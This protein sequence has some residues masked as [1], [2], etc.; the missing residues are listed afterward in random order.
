MFLM[1]ILNKFETENEDT[2]ELKRIFSSCKSNNIS[3]IN[4]K[5]KKSCPNNKLLVLP[6]NRNIKAA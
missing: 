6:L 2:K 3:C 5:Y 1:E 4:C